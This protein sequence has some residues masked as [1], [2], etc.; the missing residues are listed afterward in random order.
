MGSLTRRFDGGNHTGVCVRIVHDKAG[1]RT[2]S[3]SP[4]ITSATPPSLGACS[5]TD[6]PADQRRT[7]FGVQIRDVFEMLEG[8]SA[9]V[10]DTDVETVIETSG[11]FGHAVRYAAAAV[12][13]WRAWSSSWMSA[14]ARFSSRCLRDDVPGMSRMLGAS[15][16][17]QASAT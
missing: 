2:V 14:T 16:N 13:S 3:G 7:V 8:Q 6:P 10:K 9:F 11:S 5:V 4:S 15:P 17:V 1:I 12:S